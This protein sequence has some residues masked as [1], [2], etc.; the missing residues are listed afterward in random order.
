MKYLYSKILLIFIIASGFSQKTE[1][2]GNI[3]F[4]Q[5][6]DLHVSV[7]NANDFLLQNIVKE[8][9]NSDHEFV[10]VTGDLTNRGADDELKQVHSI[11][12]NLKI[13]YYVISGNHETNWSESAGLTYKKLWGNDR[14]VFSKGDYLFVGFPCGP[15]MKMG[16][17]FVKHE[18]VLWLDKTL[19]DSLKTVIKR[20]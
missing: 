17:G 18:N 4:V 6:T 20:Y 12:A 9:N 1:K 14:F 7:G 5:L 8:I 3:K 11:L 2:F 16:D 19:K 10:V 13:P 15:Y